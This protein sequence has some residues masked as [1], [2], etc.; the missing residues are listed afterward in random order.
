M[1]G[2]MTSRPPRVLMSTD[3]V[4]GVWTYSVQL[5]SELSR[6]GSEVG[7]ATFG[8]RPDPDQAAQALAI[9]GLRLFMS[10]FRCEWMEDAWQDVARTGLWLLEL[11][12]RFR[13]D[14]VHLNSY[15][16]AVEPFVAPV[17]VVA[18]SCVLSW[19]RQVRG[20]PAPEGLERYRRSV[21]R[22]L[23]LADRVVAPTHTMLRWL[24]ESYSS[25]APAE[26][27]P[28]GRC[29]S[30]F[31]PAPK[32]NVVFA[33]GRLWD[34]AKNLAALEWAA[35]RLQWPVEV[36]GSLRH[37]EGG[38]RRPE[39][40]RCL[41]VLAQEKIAA[42]MARAAVCAHPVRYEPFGLVPLEA[43][44][45]GCSLVLGDTETLREIWGDAALYVE[46]DDPSTLVDTLQILI[47]SR[48]LQR[49]LARRA[50]ARALRLTARRMAEAYRRLYEE[51]LRPEDAVLGASA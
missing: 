37:P 14:I 48:A 4:G 44:L 28:N 42:R 1:E 8:G 2:A 3:T 15:C 50:R 12:E 31:Q 18:H 34:E 19:W 27:I 36:A 51:L 47:G 23:R 46:P 49:R 16:N 6:L 30:L 13:P 9:P 5:A 35:T 45:S 20:A 39:G 24:R 7:L 38:T 40:V 33:C 32:K 25:L 11:E 10:D 21:A 29:P 41:G 26:V 22:G 43:A 17:V